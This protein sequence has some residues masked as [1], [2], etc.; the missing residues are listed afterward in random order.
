MRRAAMFAMFAVI[1]SASPNAFLAHAQGDAAAR[2]IFALTN[3]DRRG[4]GLAA[5]RWDSALAAA[6]QDHAD[7]MAREPALSHQYPGEAELM[8]RAA[9]TGAHFQAIAENLALG[10]SPQSMEQE[11]MH[12]T[13]HRTNILDPRMNA[14][15]I[16]VAERGG[17]L[18]AVED[19]AEATEALNRE[20]VEQR[21]R[22]L[23]VAQNVDASAPAESAE[24]ACATGRGIPQGVRSIVR[25]QTPDLNQLPTQVTN[26]IRA[27]DFRK[28]AVGACAPDP[29]QENFTTSRIAILFY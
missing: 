26:Q 10:P 29:G 1:L 7:W 16:A 17:S 15:G 6:A 28:A 19:F 4:Q 25:F 11:W 14:I 9:A 13:A 24:Q 18:Y 27:G 8:T 3:Q 20:E 21:V 22:A 23:L 5:L 12:S 2:Q